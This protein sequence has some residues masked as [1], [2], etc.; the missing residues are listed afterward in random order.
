MISD[1]ARHGN[2]QIDGRTVDPFSSDK[3]NFIQIK[4]KPSLSSNF[5][6]CQMALWGN[7]AEKLKSDACSFLDALNIKS[8]SENIPLPPLLNSNTVNNLLPKANVASVPII[9]D[10]L[11][12]LGGGNSDGNRNKQSSLFGGFIG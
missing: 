6:G 7:L 10:P 9:N 2:I 8:L 4:A 11:N 5:R 1:F 12:I 3:N